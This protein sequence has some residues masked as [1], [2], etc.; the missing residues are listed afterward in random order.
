[1][2]RS[3]LTSGSAFLLLI[4]FSASIPSLHVWVSARLPLS[5]ILFY[6]PLTVCY[7]IGISLPGSLCPLSPPPS[8]VLYPSSPFFPP[9]PHFSLFSFFSSSLNLFSSSSS[10]GFTLAL[11]LF[12]GFSFLTPSSLP[13]F[14]SIRSCEPQCLARMNGSYLSCWQ[15]HPGCVVCVCVCVGR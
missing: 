6:S 4:F 12:Q 10:P 2:S 9:C 13:L 5:F 11:F 1:M 8:T 7:Y 14:L 15:V 3:I